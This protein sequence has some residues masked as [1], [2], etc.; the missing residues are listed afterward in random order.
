MNVYLIHP[1]GRELV[2][3]I[4]QFLSEADERPAAE[5]FNER[6][7]HGGGWQPFKGFTMDQS[8]SLHY[9]GDPQIDA[10]AYMKLRDETIVVYPYAWVAIIQP[11]NS[12]EIARMD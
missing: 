10:V 7:A 9:P 4:P 6:Y 5:Q 3:F 8:W 11:D 12:F 2:G 1:A